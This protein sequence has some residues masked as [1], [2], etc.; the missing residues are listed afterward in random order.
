MAQASID[1]LPDPPSNRSGWPW[2]E[3]PT[4]HTTAFS[5]AEDWPSISI[6]TPSYNQG[7]FI[8]ETIRSVLLQGYPNLE[9]IVIDGGSDDE[10]VEILEEYDPWID[11]WVSEPD[12]GQSQA[13]N[14]GFRCA[15][16]EF[17]T[18]LNS[19]DIFLP[20]TLYT[21]GRYLRE[22]PQCK[23]LTGDGLLMDA[24]LKN[25]LHVQR[26]SSYSRKELLNYPSGQYLPQ[27]SVFFSLDLI[28]RVSGVRKDLH[29]AMDLD[30]WVRMRE[31]ARLHYVPEELSITRQHEDTKTF[32]S[33]DAAM[34]EVWMV[35]RGHL[36]NTWSLRGLK[37]YLRLRQLRARNV[38]NQGLRL[39]HSEEATEAKSCLLEALRLYPPVAVSRR[40]VSLLFRIFAPRSLQQYLL[41]RPS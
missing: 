13:I 37:L 17:G 22:H 12:D 6:I 25:K 34:K 24:P 28:G 8:E 16:G 36:D 41:S 39:L 38:R 21:I 1:V 27:P 33:N 20:T 7:C 19:D 18:W 5:D 40:W 31:E 11:Y 26:P 30:L 23:F 15:N 3:A 32:G 29:Y 2:T 35:L 10:T 14:T 4:S 9:Y